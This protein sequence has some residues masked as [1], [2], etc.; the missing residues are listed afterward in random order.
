M[1]IA[2]EYRIQAAR[3]Q[4]WDALNDPDVLKACI[5]GCDSVE[6]TSDTAFSA[7]VTAKVG[8]VK[9]KFAGDVTLSNMNPP[10]SYTITGEGKGGAAGFAK[11][12][13]DVHLTEDGD[14]TVLNY[15]VQA[16]VGG[17]LAQLGARLIQGTARKMA[18]DFFGR[19]SELVESQASDRS[20]PVKD[21]PPAVA[22]APAETSTEKPVDA[23]DTMGAVQDAAPADPVDAAPPPL[24]KPTRE[25]AP[26]EAAPA[27]T[28]ET[29]APVDSHG[30]D[31][32]DDHATDPAPADHPHDTSPHDG[33]AG[34]PP[35]VW[36]AAIIL[37]AG[38]LIVAFG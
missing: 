16:N 11:G 25:P 30:D 28:A 27:A 19:F 8:P 31:R 1:D 22:E 6:K 4:V 5:P 21:A 3:Q 12:G 37:V 7:K 18:D 29:P 20:A 2:G 23:P 10:E 15:T 33:D 14:A 9:A 26:V 38:I 36:V 17:K 34:L 13:A 35:W 32:G 24:A